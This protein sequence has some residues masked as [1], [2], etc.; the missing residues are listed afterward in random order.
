MLEF[1][2]WHEL[3]RLVLTFFI[4]LTV[5][6]QA[7]NVVISVSRRRG[8][9]KRG[10]ENMLEGWV[11]CHLL[12]LSLLHG[13]IVQT[14]SIGMIVPTGYFTLRVIAWGLVFF[15]SAVVAGL[16]KKFMP[17]Y[18]GLAASLTLPWLEALTGGVFPYLFFSAILIFL[19]RGVH[20]IIRRNRETRTSLSALSIK[21]TI[22]HLH[23]G[24]LF[25]DKDGFILLS[26]ARMQGLMKTIAGEIMRNG[27]A[28]YQ[29]LL[30][31]TLCEG[32]V[33]MRS[34]GGIVCLTPDQS[35]WLF[36]TAVLPYKKKNFIQLTATDVTRRWELTDRLRK[37]EDELTLIGQA[38]SEAV[39]ESYQLIRHRETER[40]KRRAHDVLGQRLSFI[41]RTIRSGATVDKALLHSLSEGLLEELKKEKDA[42]TPK[43]ELNSL[44]QALASIGVA[45]DFV[46]DLPDA[47]EGAKLMM[48]IIREAVTNAVRHGFATVIT[49]TVE[50]DDKGHLLAVTNDGQLPARPITERGGLTGMK[51][52]LEPYGGT[53]MIELD[54][55][56]TLKARLPKGSRNV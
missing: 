26:N 35:A 7:L 42:P 19:V 15:S 54:P 33:R 48:N 41:L 14:W 32:C 37:Q 23:T 38:L 34:E 24:V 6:L 10:L 13:E 30:G 40:A 51:K 16:S 49:A 12:V 20:I 9:I 2:R 27:E 53:L 46:G 44:S 8:G 22:D 36:K 25:S 17:L 11:L 45:F 43:D 56:F 39:E 29:L 31:G 47:Q 52:R 1:Y 55:C 4:A 28:F 5:L 50:E 3:S 21:N 18:V